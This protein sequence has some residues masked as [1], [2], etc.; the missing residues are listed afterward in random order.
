M[1]EELCRLPLA[2]GKRTYIDKTFA[3]TKISA[4]HLFEMANSGNTTCYSSSAL[5]F[6]SEYSELYE[7]EAMN[8]D[9]CGP[10]LISNYVIHQLEPIVAMLK[11]KPIRAMSVGT[12]EYP[13]VIIEYEKGKR[14]KVATYNSSDVFSMYIGYGNSEEKFVKV[15]SNFWEGFIKKLGKFYETGEIPVPRENT[16]NVIA[17]RELV[18]KALKKSYEWVY[19]K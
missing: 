1:H 12:Q 8:I 10:G 16:V 6:A 5:Y 13:A 14:A 7:Y 2:S 11:A 3:E 17:S 9:S 19:L 15:K 18:I 4:E